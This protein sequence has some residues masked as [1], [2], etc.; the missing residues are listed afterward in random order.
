[1]I[2]TSLVVGAVFFFFGYLIGST[3]NE[4]RWKAYFRKGEFV[5]RVNE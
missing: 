3:V 5:R 1:M 4:R 2:I